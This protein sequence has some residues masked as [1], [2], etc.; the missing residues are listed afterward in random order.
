MELRR[1]FVTKES[2][3]ESTE[4]DAT[5]DLVRVVNKRPTILHLPDKLQTMKTRGEGELRTVGFGTGKSLIPGGNNVEAKEWA[6]AKKNKAVAQWIRLGWLVEGGDTAEPEGPLAPLNLSNVGVQ[7]ALVMV[8]G[9]NDQP[10]LM[11]WLKDE[12]RA[13]VQGAIKAKLQAL[14]M[15]RAKG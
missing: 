6:A 12:D 15:K 14:G 7:T 10:V 1:L 4:A 5:M 2:E 13:D 3:M 11:R 8:E 9:E